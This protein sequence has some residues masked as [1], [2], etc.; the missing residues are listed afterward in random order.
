MLSDAECADIWGEFRPE[1]AWD[2]KSLS[3]IQEDRRR[4]GSEKSVSFKSGVI[5]VKFLH[6]LK[7]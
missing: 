4:G 5:E 6:L 7:G 3:Q 1:L 2:R